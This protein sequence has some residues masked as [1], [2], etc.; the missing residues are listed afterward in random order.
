MDEMKCFEDNA[1][2]SSN[3]LSQKSLEINSKN[4]N[5]SETPFFQAVS[6]AEEHLEC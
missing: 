6:E 2:A 3:D 1:S 5:Q 4:D